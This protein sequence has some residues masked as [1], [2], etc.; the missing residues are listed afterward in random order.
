M[1]YKI[2]FDRSKRNIAYE[3]LLP[4]IQEWFYDSIIE[5]M[6]K[7]INTMNIIDRAFAGLV[8]ITI[9]SVSNKKSPNWN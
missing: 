5:M 9:I 6:K 8:Y 3:S 4:K 1:V 7:K 2:Y